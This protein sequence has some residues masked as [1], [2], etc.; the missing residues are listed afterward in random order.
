M[1]NLDVT[2]RRR[3]VVAAAVTI[4]ALPAI[5]LFARSEPSTGPATPTVA[6]PAGVATPGARTSRSPDTANDPLGAD[7]PIFVDGPTTPPRPVVVAIAVPA[8]PPGK[9]ID[10]EATYKRN[11][12]PNATG[13]SAPLAGFNATLTVTNLDNGQFITCVNRN[14]RP[15]PSGV[16][17]ELTAAQF[18]HIAQLVDAP[19]HVRI[20]WNSR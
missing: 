13:C 3:L 18:E 15:L 11:A 12:D 9:Y 6:A 14:P 8:T 19:V 17:V 10:G 20:Q 1:L 7:E 16:S 5:W 2:D 4:V